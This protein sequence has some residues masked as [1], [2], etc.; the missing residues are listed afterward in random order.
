MAIL[1][2][3][4]TGDYSA[5]VHERPKNY[6]EAILYLQRN[7]TAPLTAILTKLKREMV[8]DP[9]FNWFEKDLP[10][11]KTTITAPA[12]AQA[13]FSTTPVAFTVASTDG[14]RVNDVCRIPATGET[15]LITVV[16]DATHF[17]AL[18]SLGDSGQDAITASDEVIVAGSAQAEGA[19][20][21]LAKYFDPTRRYN[22]TEIF[23]NP[24]SVTGTQDMTYFRT[25]N[26]YKN[27][28]RE[29]FLQHTT[30]MERAFL[31]GNAEIVS[32]TVSGLSS[33]SGRPLRTTGGIFG[34][35]YAGSW[36]VPAA[37]RWTGETGAGAA[38][39]GGNITEDLFDQYLETVMKS[40]SRE[41]IAFCGPTAMRAMSKL[42]KSSGVI[43]LTPVK[44]GAYGFHL[45]EWISPFGSVYLKLH[46]L[47]GETTEDSQTILLVE[48]RN[49]KYR[50]L[51][52][53]G[54]KLLKDRQS[55]GV[56][57]RTDEYLTECGIEIHHGETHGIIKGV[58]D[59]A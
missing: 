31:F 26:A 1:G 21:R 46:P 22:L 9:E 12:T 4:G 14:F 47:L 32:S 24:I 41:R 5:N 25:G 56:D 10:T 58:Q 29:S 54:T 55:P 30:E 57:G 49:L 8:D 45:K 50:F 33:T 34:S 44:N 19:D 48:P 11:V 39:A 40:G 36:F 52:G 18:R 7:G 15:I 16:T 17:S 43:N 35:D 13:A 23:R 37:N 27:R 51:K 42:A 3:S 28:K 20:V 2:M 53:R 59:A 38:P 6:R